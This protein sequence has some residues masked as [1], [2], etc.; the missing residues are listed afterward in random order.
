MSSP[1]PVAPSPFPSVPASMRTLPFKTNPQA[2][3][4]PSIPLNWA[5]MPSQNQGLLLFIPDVPSSAT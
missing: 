1:F 3:Q 4:K 2:P 5:N